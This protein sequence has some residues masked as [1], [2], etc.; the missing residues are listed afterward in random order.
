MQSVPRYGYSDKQ[1]DMDQKT[2]CDEEAG[3]MSKRAVNCRA[4]YGDIF[5]KQTD[6]ENAEM[7]QKVNIAFDKISKL[8]LPTRR[9]LC[10]L[11]ERA[12]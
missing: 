2:G 4:I 10:G 7:V 9:I 12:D 11:V 8:T 6:D 1:Y 5:R 3:T